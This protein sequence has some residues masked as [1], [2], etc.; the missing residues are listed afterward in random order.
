LLIAGRVWKSDFS[1]YAELIELH[2]LA[3][4]CT[5]HIRY[6]EDAEAAYF[7]LCA[8]LV[9]LPYLRIY[10]SGVVLEAMSHGS[11][12]LVS[13]IPG[14]LEVIDDERTGF[15]FK[16]GDPAH[17]SQRIAEAF[18]VPGHSTQVA[19]AG[20][21]AVQ[22]RNDWSRLGEQSVACYRRALG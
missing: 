22:E 7:Y 6:I 18:T 4:H 14:M 8:D 1:R 16:S 21:R 11:P 3:P 17:L 19:R 9:V 15:V 13:D 5:L 10:Q 20:L 2:A 12:V